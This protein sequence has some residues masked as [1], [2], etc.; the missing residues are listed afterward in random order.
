MSKTKR[1]RGRSIKRD[2]G[3]RRYK[4]KYMKI[5]GN[6]IKNIEAGL[7]VSIDHIGEN[8]KPD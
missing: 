2:S 4:L 1:T 3:G 5:A 6:I 7:L 8:A